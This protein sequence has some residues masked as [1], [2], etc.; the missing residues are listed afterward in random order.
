[1]CQHVEVA[2]VQ[3]I[4]HFAAILITNPN[5]RRSDSTEEET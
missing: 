5:R 2:T 4:A 3:A 1:M